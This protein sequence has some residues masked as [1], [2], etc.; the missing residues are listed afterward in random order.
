MKRL[1]AIIACH[2]GIVFW[3]VTQNQIYVKSFVGNYDLD[4]LRE[5]QTILSEGIPVF[6]ETHVNTSDFG[7]SL[8]L[9][10]GYVRSLGK[11]DNLGVS[12]NFTGIQSVTSAED[13][14]FVNQLIFDLERWSL[15]VEWQRR[16]FDY[17][18]TIVR[19]SMYYSPISLQTRSRFIPGDWRTSNLKYFAWGPSL[20]P[21]IGWEKSFNKWSFGI[22][23]GYEFTILHGD[24]QP[25]GHDFILF[26]ANSEVGELDW[27]G[28]RLGIILS[29]SL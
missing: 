19:G 5:I 16:W 27:S 15:S 1:I 12:F 29:Y 7:L 20:T 22:E 25:K 6:S 28:W 21:A 23:G 24:I 11:R 17:F 13:V 4:D 26:N 9:E 8:Q 18:F 10:A 2:L 3:A 14:D